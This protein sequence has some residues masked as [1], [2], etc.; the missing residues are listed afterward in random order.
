MTLA[1]VAG[2]ALMLAGCGDG[3]QRVRV[4]GQVTF[5][6]KPVKYGNLVF[7][8]DQSRGNRGPQGYARISDGMYDTN[9]AGTGPCPGPQ[10]VYIEGYPELDG[11]APR[12]SRLVFKHRTTADLSGKTATVDF[13][14]PA[15]AAY[16]ETVSDLPPP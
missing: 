11:G 8:P 2:L 1:A 7:E 13:D 10:V 4:S 3:T 9:N 14:V 5:Q 12:K 6:G 15:S 16:R